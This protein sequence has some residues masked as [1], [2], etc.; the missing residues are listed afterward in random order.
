M[1]YSQKREHIISLFLPQYW[2]VKVNHVD[3]SGKPEGVS[4]HGTG[5]CSPVIV[6]PQTAAA[7][8]AAQANLLLTA[9]ITTC[10][11]INWQ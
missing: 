9:S 4:S 3:N 11:S 1:S 6:V 10:Q 8:A 7:A 2:S 5:P